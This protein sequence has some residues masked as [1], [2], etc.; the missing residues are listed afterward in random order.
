MPSLCLW[1]MWLYLTERRTC[2]ELTA[3]VCR[4]DITRVSSFHR[5]RLVTEALG[6]C[7]LMYAVFNSFRIL[8]SI[9]NFVCKFDDISAA[10]LAI[11]KTV[12]VMGP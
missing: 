4:V 1:E 11:D 3:H 7:H 12:G 6:L 2:V 8:V 5:P 9:V 10:M